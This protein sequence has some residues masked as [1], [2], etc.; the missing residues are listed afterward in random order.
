MRRF[1]RLA[2]ACTLIHS[3]LPFQAAPRRAPQRTRRRT[4]RS[5]TAA[6]WRERCDAEGVISYYDFGVRL[7]NEHAAAAPKQSATSSFAKALDEALRGDSTHLREELAS[8]VI[9][10]HGL[11]EAKG[12]QAALKLVA[13]AAEFYDDARLDVLASTE[14]EFRWLASGTQPVQWSPRAV[15]YTHLTLPTKA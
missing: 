14:N 4:Q 8:D 1:R 15:S 3:A 13:E 2:A 9:W 5:A 12:A 7:H 10:Q 6:D 11:G